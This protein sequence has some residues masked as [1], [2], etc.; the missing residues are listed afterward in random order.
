[1][2]AKWNEIRRKKDAHYAPGHAVLQVQCG[3]RALTPESL[4]SH[5]GY[6]RR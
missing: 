5:A 3:V 1:M 6:M 2:K 4:G